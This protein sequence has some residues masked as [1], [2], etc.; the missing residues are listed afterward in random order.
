LWTAIVGVTFGNTSSFKPILLL[1]DLTAT[2]I[3][4]DTG[5]VFAQRL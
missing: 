4:L 5:I 2:S 1:I 3:W